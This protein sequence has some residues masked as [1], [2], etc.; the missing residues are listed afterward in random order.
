MGPVP[1]LEVA[2]TLLRLGLDV[3]VKLDWERPSASPWAST[4]LGRLKTGLLEV[5]PGAVVVPL[6]FGFSTFFTRLRIQRLL[7]T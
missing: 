5:E 2:D 6:S 7:L 1:M 4:L 3:E